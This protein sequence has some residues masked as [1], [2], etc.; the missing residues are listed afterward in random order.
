MCFNISVAKKKKKLEQRFEAEFEPHCAFLFS[1]FSFSAFTH[2]SVPV[3]TNDEP[4][5]IQTYTWGLIPHWVRNEDQ[6]ADISTKTF[7]ARVETAGVKPLFL[8]SLK[9]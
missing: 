4:S 3:I 7:N 8:D 5:V 6:A 2:P 1:D 9:P